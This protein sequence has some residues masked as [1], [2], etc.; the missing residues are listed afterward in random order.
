M[1]TG[2]T[3]QCTYVHTYLR[4]VYILS[5]ATNLG[6]LLKFAYCLDPIDQIIAD[7][8]EEGPIVGGTNSPSNILNKLTE[9]KFESRFKGRRFLRSTLE[10]GMGRLQTAGLRREML[11][12]QATSDELDATLMVQC[13]CTV[14]LLSIHCVKVCSLHNICT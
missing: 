14:S 1:S 11:Q 5:T 3:Y 4:C 6:N 8:E 12:V 2:T 10:A 9:S 13:V 7:L